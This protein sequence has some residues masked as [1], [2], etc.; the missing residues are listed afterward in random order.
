MLFPALAS[1]TATQTQA[2]WATDRPGQTS[3]IAIVRLIV[4]VLLLIV[5][6]PQI[7]ILGPAIALVAGYVAVIILSS[8]ALRPFLTRP[9]RATWPLRE[10]GALA[11]AYGAGFLATHEVER[12]LPSLGGLLLALVAG[13]LAYGTAFTVG[14]AVN[15]RD[16]KRLADM[17]DLLA[18]KRAQRAARSGRHEQDG[19]DEPNTGTLAPTPPIEI[20]VVADQG[21]R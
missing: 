14:G 7:G 17:R 9:V 10:Q 1:A 20:D 18:S 13:T 4:T 8:I 6:T 3:V 19:A 21:T 2:L 16:R 5:L 15:E 12:V 11:A